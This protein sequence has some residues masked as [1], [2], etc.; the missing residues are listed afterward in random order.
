MN[1][2]AFRY[3]GE[4]DFIKR[5]SD[6]LIIHAEN[7]SRSGFVFSPFS[8]S[9]R[10]FKII[11][12]WDISFIPKDLIVDNEVE[13][14]S[15]ISTK[16]EH[17]RYVEQIISTLGESE[18]GKVVAA[19]TL[20]LKLKIDPEELLKRL[21]NAYPDAFIFFVSTKEFGSWIGASPELLIERKGNYWQSVALAGTRPRGSD[22]DWD[23]KNITEQKVVSDYID[24]LFSRYGLEVAE[25]QKMTVT[26]GPVEHIKT[27]FKAH[28][29]PQG[30]AFELV[31]E[32]SPTPALC[33][34]PKQEAVKIIKMWEGESR[35]LY[36]GFVG[37]YETFDSF[38]LYV[39][40]RSALL[41]STEILLYAGGGIL[42]ESDP[43]AEW[44]ETERKLN[45]LRNLL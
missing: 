4:K 28:G 2:Y 42:K 38:S 36:G 31:S 19:R 7:D 43:D 24:D 44:E 26:A 3:P 29:N 30:G 13:F 11:E 15:S 16:E 5:I 39:N 34:Y 1:V 12:G 33:G 40:L 25:T 20:R 17:R 35:R 37:W 41:N 10:I 22:S 23:L 6:K 21:A 14:P 45:T 9:D 27:I 18:D 32:L 8:H